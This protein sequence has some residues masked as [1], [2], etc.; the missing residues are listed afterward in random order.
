MTTMNHLAWRTSSF[1]KGNE[2]VEVA[3]PA[4]TAAIRDSK[5][6]TGPQLTVSHTEFAAFLATITVH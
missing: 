2:C 1:S 4:E 5:N 3:W 6:P